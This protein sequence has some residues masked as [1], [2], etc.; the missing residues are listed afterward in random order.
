MTSLT[1]EPHTP[2]SQCSIRAR[3][4]TGLASGSRAP[5]KR[6]NQRGRD[7]GKRKVGRGGEVEGKW[8][9]AKNEVV[10]QLG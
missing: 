6:W 4:S 10:A 7:D 2:V 1:P 3:K 9:W 8:R 5:V